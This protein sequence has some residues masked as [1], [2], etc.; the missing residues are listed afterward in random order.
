MAN[1]QLTAVGIKNIKVDKKT[2]FRDGNGL[3]LRVR[4]SGRKLWV[5]R[6]KQ[7][8]SNKYTNF[9]IGEYPTM[10]L[11][12]ARKIAEN[13]ANELKK[14]NDPRETLDKFKPTFFA[15]AEKWFEWRKTRNNFTE[16]TAKD[17]WRLLELNLFP[18][19]GDEKI[20]NITAP[21][22]IFELEKIQA[23]GK[24]ETRKRAMGKM[25]EIFTYA[26]NVGIIEH[27]P[28]VNIS[29]MFD[30]PRAKH[31]ATMQADELKEIFSALRYANVAAISF[32]LL[33]FQ[34]LTLCRPVEAASARWSDIDLDQK[35]WTYK[36]LKGNKEDESGRVHK[37]PLNS[38]AIAIL[39]RLVKF[40]KKEDYVF[41]N[42]AN[43]KKHASSQTVNEILKR[44]GFAG[45]QTAHGFRRMASTWL[46]EQHNEDGSRKYDAELIEVALSHIDRNTV[47]SAYNSAEY[48][49]RRRRMLQD[50][51]DFV[52]K[53]GL[54]I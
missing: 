14:G 40:F 39:E 22:V 45:K 13:H 2:D 50:W 12:E 10:G 33:A 26:L 19:F 28:L 6:F 5:F 43:K 44:C 42:S 35:I 41:P 11:A 23:T 31:L 48:I 20:H 24:A 34:L 1:Y 9:K 7:S 16:K 46:N 32:S 37:V 49:E 38:Q 8:G 47:R 4:P 51:G 15:V 29:S 21:Q 52:E 3:M 27:N 18:V 17:T 53:S 54:Q 30:K 25:C 36:V